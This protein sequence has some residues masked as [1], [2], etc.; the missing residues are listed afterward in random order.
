M[1]G[2]KAEACAT[3]PAAFQALRGLIGGTGRV[4]EYWDER[5]HNSVA[6]ASFVDVPEPGLTTYSTV[7]LHQV[8]NELDGQDLRVELIGTVPTGHED[9]ANVLATCAFTV[10]KEGW[11]AAPGV[12]FPDAVRQYFPRSTTPHLMWTEP[13]AWEGLSTLQLEGAGAVHWL[14]G[15]PLSDAEVEL[16]DRDGRDA[17]EEALETSAA[18][19]VDLERASATP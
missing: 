10:A 16:L 6:I 15:L 5:E 8:P 11:L 13:F 7:T 9:F 19:L 17:L 18:P 3:G 1:T 14:A 12:V 4:H 2:M